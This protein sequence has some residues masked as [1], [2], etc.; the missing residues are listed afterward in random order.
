MDT[1]RTASLPRCGAVWLGSTVVAGAL[2]AC[3][4]PTIAAGPEEV[5]L[6]RALV[7]VCA[8]A[9]VAVASWLWLVTGLVALEALTGRTD[10][11]PGVPASVRRVVLAACGVALVGGLATPAIAT[12]GDPHEARGSVSLA[13]L[14][15]PDRAVSTALPGGAHV[16]TGPVRSRDRTAEVVVAPG[17][18]LWAIASRDLG[19]GASDAQ[20]AGRTHEL[21]RL[22]LAQIGPD[23]DLIQPATRLRLH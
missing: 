21:Y 10:A 23:P 22:N 14:P 11:T 8:V 13:G 16:H 19:P 20:V 7:W 18:S 17:D 1:S 6:D 9:A 4:L 2:V 3:L 15:L 12:P 5:R